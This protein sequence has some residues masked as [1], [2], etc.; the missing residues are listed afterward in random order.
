MTARLQSATKSAKPI[1]LR[2]S[3]DTGHGQGTPLAE[4]V[5]QE[6]DVFAFLVSQ[7]QME[8]RAGA[9]RSSR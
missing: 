3:F 7:L 6:A 5:A 9:D 4:R 2:Y 1:L 8:E